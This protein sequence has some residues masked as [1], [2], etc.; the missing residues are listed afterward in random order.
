MRTITHCYR[1]ARLLTT[2]SAAGLLS[3][4]A[5]AQVSE[6]PP[7]APPAANMPPSGAAGPLDRASPT[8]SQ[9]AQLEDII[10]TAQRRQEAAQSV[11]VA[12]TA[13]SSAALQRAAI[14]DLQSLSK[15]VVGIQYDAPQTQRPELYIRGIGTNRF[16]VGS[17]PSSGTYIDEIYQ[18]RFADVLTGLVD[19]DRVEILRGPQGTLFGRNTIGG[20]ISAYTAEPSKDLAVQ[21]TGTYGNRDDVAGGGTVSV[22]F[23][24]NILGRFTAGYRNRDGFMRDTVSGKDNGVQAFTLRGKLRFIL[25]PRATLNVAAMHFDSKQS[26]ILED[27]ENLP[28]YLAGPL[29]PQSLDGS[30]YSGAYT[31]PG[32][33]HVRTTQLS[34]RLD[35]DNDRVKTSFIGSYIQFAQDAS[36]DLD[37]SVLDSVSYN[38]RERSKTYSLEFR[39]S[40]QPG[41]IATFGDRFRWVGG[42]YLF[43]DQGSDKTG[44]NIGTDNILTFLI[45]NPVLFVDPT[46]PGPYT[47]STY[48]YTD[49]TI[50]TSDLKS[51]AA[52]AQ[53]T[54]DITRKLGLTVGGRYTN[55]QRKFS[56][57]ATPDPTKPF[58]GLPVV[59][60]A[61]YYPG[62]VTA[63]KF[64]PRVAIEYKLFKDVLLYASYSKGFK[65]GAV[66]SSAFN[67]AVAARVTKPET[68]DAYEVG[69][70][71][72]FFN[73]R[74][75]L[76]VSIFENKFKNL[77]V[78][79]VETVGGFSTAITENAATS[80]I[81]GVELEASVLPTRFLQ[82]NAS[83]AY[84]DAR[85]DK[86]VVDAIRNIDF[87]GN[88]LPRAPK[89]RF[90]IDTNFNYKFNGGE[91]LDIRAAY[92]YTGKFFFQPDNL[93][94]ER[95][96][97][98]GLTD[99]SA[100]LTLANGTTKIQAWGRNLFSVEY[101]TYLDPLDTSRLASWSDKATYGVTL[102]QKF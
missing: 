51:I 44:Y 24:S 21:I 60:S 58:P 40:S 77:Q 20:A 86:Y 32:G 35:L 81:K 63:A 22:P 9:P 87:S 53:G 43:Q 75:R 78:R 49:R 5:I 64:D 62:K 29:A 95:E 28:I 99:L 69:L 55:D 89:N 80:T 66:Q 38:G 14:T 26:A 30:R 17:D 4:V 1:T 13:V 12:I 33:N 88:H 31:T 11:P 84:L 94:I 98:Y 85:F 96:K 76:N 72:E 73:R 37:G 101:R 67:P 92:N 36:Q 23:T 34:A 19:L 46:Y 15:S 7:E 52:Y 100:T 57:S 42:V 6:R 2:A 90:N 27:P 79:R 83:Y 10:V 102:T 45:A 82:F 16:D 68:V 70:K 48:R 18:P 47:A 71:S 25:G 74:A 54:F 65:S 61:F 93:P 39:L 3:S 59:A 97:D 8:P 56:F 41:G 91:R 50:G